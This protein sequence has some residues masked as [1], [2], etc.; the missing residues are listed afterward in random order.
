MEVKWCRMDV[1][2]SNNR[3]GIW[4]KEFTDLWMCALHIAQVKL[5]LWYLHKQTNQI[6]SWHTDP[7]CTLRSWHRTL[8]QTHTKTNT[9]RAVTTAHTS[10][11][12]PTPC[13][14]KRSSSLAQLWYCDLLWNLIWVCTSLYG[15]RREQL[16]ASWDENKIEAGISWWRGPTPWLEISLHRTEPSSVIYAAENRFHPPPCFPISPSHS[17]PAE[18]ISR[19]LPLSPQLVCLLSLYLS[20][21]CILWQSILWYWQLCRHLSEKGLLFYFSRKGLTYK[22]TEFT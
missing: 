7:N 3:R 21:N 2:T 16:A 12:I 13:M 9:S 14:W 10:K 18:A 8:L 5:N 17:F 1:A 15:R 11:N 20:D 6:L 22:I 4:F 19:I